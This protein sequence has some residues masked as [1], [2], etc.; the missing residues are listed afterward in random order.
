MSEYFL[1]R[2]SGVGQ[3]FSEASTFRWI[4][5]RS[6]NKKPRSSNVFYIVTAKL[7]CLVKAERY[8]PNRKPQGR[9]HYGYEKIPISTLR[10][11]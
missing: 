9:D 10:R 3:I 6:K 4:F 11:K 8:Y 1:M 2:N 7:G 5:R